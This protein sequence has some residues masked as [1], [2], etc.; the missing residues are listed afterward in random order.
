MTLI[1]WATGNLPT[2]KKRLQELVGIME[3]M[4]TDGECRLDGNQIGDIYQWLLWTQESLS[5]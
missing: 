3:V 1:R 2:D 4:T 5:K